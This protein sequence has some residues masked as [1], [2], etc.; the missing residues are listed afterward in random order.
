M[1]GDRT[2]KTDPSATKNVTVDSGDGGAYADH[3][4]LSGK[5]LSTSLRD[6]QDVSHEHTYHSYWSHNTAQYDGL[7]NARFVTRVQDRHQ[8]QDQRRLARTH[9][10]ERV[11]QLR[12]RLHHLRPAHAHR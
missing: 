9:G 10:G 11:R 3:D 2:S 1:D 7:P 8:H 4:W 6:D 5:V 12:S